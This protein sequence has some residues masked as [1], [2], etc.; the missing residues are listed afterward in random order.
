MNSY[1]FSALSH[2]FCPKGQE[3]DLELNVPFSEIVAICVG[4]NGPRN[5]NIYKAG[6]HRG[7]SRDRE[8]KI[9][10]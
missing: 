6:Q 3:D 2:E 7:L 1:P 9:S 8:A 4:A 5:T 10:P